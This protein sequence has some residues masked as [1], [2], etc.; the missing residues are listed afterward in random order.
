M[1]GSGRRR[2]A[3][4]G[5]WP[6]GCPFVGY[7]W[8]TRGWCGLGALRATSRLRLGRWFRVRVTWGGAPRLRRCALPQATLNWPF[9]PKTYWAAMFSLWP[10]LLNTRSGGAGRG[11]GQAN[12]GNKGITQIRDN[13]RAGV[14]NSERGLGTLFL[15]A[16]LSHKEL[17]MTH[18]SGFVADGDTR[19]R[20][21][22]ASRVRA[23][24]ERE[25]AA[26]IRNATSFLQRL[27]L[28]WQIDRVVQSRLDQLAPPDALY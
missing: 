11:G 10:D 23:E 9:R 8:A 16:A 14:V 18:S 2:K 22:N 6:K 25:F 15:W 17:A 21:A 13:E 27:R 20:D 12:D 28:R 26:A 3:C 7:F 24:V 1:Y 19:V 4:P 5:V